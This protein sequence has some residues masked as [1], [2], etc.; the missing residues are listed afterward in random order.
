MLK[1]FKRVTTT[2]L[3]T[4]RYPDEAEPAPERYRGQV[5]L[6]TARC[7]GDAACVR[8]C[9]SG[10]IAVEPAD[11]GWIWRLDDARCVFCGLC[12]DACANKAVSLSNE[13]E[14]AVR[15][16]ADLGTSVVFTRK[17]GNA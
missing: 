1:L 6:D 16:P 9:P 13:F 3:V 4:G 14:L 11:A 7:Q 15:N 2:G 17:A 8:V 10:A 12:Q 5:L